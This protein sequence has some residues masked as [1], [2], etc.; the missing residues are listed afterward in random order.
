MLAVSTFKLSQGAHYVPGICIV[1]D[2]EQEAME[3]ARMTQAHFELPGSKPSILV[4]ID[5][6]GP[7]TCKLFVDFAPEIGSITVAG[8]TA[9]LATELLRGLEQSPQYVVFSAHNHLNPQVIDPHTFH[10]AKSDVFIDGVHVKGNPKIKI[11]W[12]SLF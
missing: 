11:D 12:S 3:L 10:L 9:E 6:D 1:A 2:S 4:A 8:V 5:R 7:T